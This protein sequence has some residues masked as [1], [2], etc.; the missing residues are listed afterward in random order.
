ML[1]RSITSDLDSESKETMEKVMKEW[2]QRKRGVS[3]Y[4]TW[5]SG[6]GN[7]GNFTLPL[8]QGEWDEPL[9]V[10]LC[11]VCHNVCVS[12]GCTWAG[13]GLI[14]A[15]NRPIRSTV[16]RS[17]RTGKRKSLTSCYNFYALSS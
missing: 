8:S 15:S 10:P 7:E 4:D 16:W 11:V 6:T 5:G 1:L 2:Q 3:T 14:V 9:G 13:K 17:S 12:K